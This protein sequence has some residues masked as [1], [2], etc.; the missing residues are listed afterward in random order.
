MTITQKADTLWPDWRRARPAVESILVV[1]KFPK[2]GRCRVLPSPPTEY[3]E[4]LRRVHIPASLWE[5]L[6]EY[7]AGTLRFPREKIAYYLIHDYTL[8]QLWALQVQGIVIV[9]QIRHTARGIEGVWDNWEEAFLPDKLPDPN[10]RKPPKGSFWPY[11]LREHWCQ[12][13]T[14]PLTNMYRTHKLF[15]DKQYEDTRGR[16]GYKLYRTHMWTIRRQYPTIDS[17]HYLK[18]LRKAVA[19]ALVHDERELLRYKWMASP[20]MLRLL[21]AVLLVRPVFD[22][23]GSVQLVRMSHE[24]QLE[25]WQ[26]LRERAE[27]QS[28]LAQFKTALRREPK[29]RPWRRGVIC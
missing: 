12:V 16:M 6:I 13:I 9:P 22:Y 28:F 11:S 20:E 29:T 21:L 27:S 3:M 18:T 2:Y 8:E 10:F 4:Q 24:E 19:R 14:S 25:E 23:D 7:K 1:D 26:W 17:K 5:L 15:V